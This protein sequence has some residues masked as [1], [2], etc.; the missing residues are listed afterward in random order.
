MNPTGKG[1]GGGD[2]KVKISIEQNFIE[3]QT[4]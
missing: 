2:G 1:E 3:I 4:G